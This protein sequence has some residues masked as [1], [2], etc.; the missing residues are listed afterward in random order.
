MQFDAVCKA[1]E[2][3]ANPL[4]S[5][6]RERFPTLDSQELTTAVDDVFISLAKKA[7]VG[8]FQAD[9]SLASLLFRMARNKAVDQLKAK[10]K[11]EQRWVDSS[12]CFKGEQPGCSD[13]EVS[14]DEIIS[15]VARKLSNAPE[16]AAAWRAVMQDWTPA[17]EVAAI[18]IVRQ[19]KLWIAD[20]PRLQRKV[21]EVMAIHFGN[22]TDEEICDEIA[23][24]D[25]RPEIASVKSARREIREKF[26]TLI[27][28]Q[29][30]IKTA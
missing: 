2:R 7:K 4:A 11:Q 21:A 8:N 15:M 17:H 9:G 25:E 5:Y 29:E 24:K 30:R 10:Y 14:Q 27:E 28:R 26:K 22:I 12:R 18:E 3:Y 20:L 1:Y 13:D 6:L 19:F 16:I 23:K